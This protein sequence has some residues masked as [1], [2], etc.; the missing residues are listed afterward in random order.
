M[1]RCWM[2]SVTR[3][4]PLQLLAVSTPWLHHP[5]GRCP[6]RGHSTA[7]V[8]T[9]AR[10]DDQHWHSS[11][12]VPG[13]RA[14]GWDGH[15]TEQFPGDVWAAGWVAVGV[16]PWWNTAAWRLWLQ[17]WVCDVVEQRTYLQCQHDYHLSDDCAAELHDAVQGHISHVCQQ[18]LQYSLLWSVVWHPG[19]FN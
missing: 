17:Y 6:Y 16:P 7:L 8:A 9:P 18:L 12:V 4:G 13:Q 19:L 3:S 2:A 1:C 11:W 15:C 5:P 14:C 10:R